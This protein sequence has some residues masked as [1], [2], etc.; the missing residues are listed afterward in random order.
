[1]YINW[2]H[3]IVSDGLPIVSTLVKLYCDCTVIMYN[4]P[5]WSL[6]RHRAMSQNKELKANTVELQEAFVRISNQNMELATE[7]DTERRR[8]AQLKLLQAPPAETATPAGAQLPSSSVPT[9][10]ASTGEA[11]P[12]ASLM[13]AT[14]H[15]YSSVEVAQNGVQ[16]DWSGDDDGLVPGK[17][18]VHPVGV[19]ASPEDSSLTPSMA[20]VLQYSQVRIWLNLFRRTQISIALQF[21]QNMYEFS[22][23]M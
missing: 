3:L 10:V 14:G 18:A 22:V 1:M 5:S 4:L 20:E 8:L 7:L 2:L 6:S 11:M 12:A 9:S 15:E 21:F 16:T 19:A 13:T 23:S 17:E